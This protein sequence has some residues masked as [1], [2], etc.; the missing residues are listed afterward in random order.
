[1]LLR[2]GWGRAAG[3]VGG[4]ERPGWGRGLLL[5]SFEGLRPDVSRAKEYINSSA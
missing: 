2:C 1:M 5:R 3:G 4:A